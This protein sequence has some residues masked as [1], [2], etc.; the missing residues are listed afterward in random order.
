MSAGDIFSQTLVYIL[1]TVSCANTFF[2]KAIDD[3]PGADDELSAF[4]AFEAEVLPLIKA[5][6][7]SDVE[8]EC[9]LSRRVFPTTAPNRVFSLTGNGTVT[10]ESLPAN[11]AMN[12]RHFSGIGTKNQRGRWFFSG[13]NEARVVE[14]RMVGVHSIPMDALI[15]VVSNP[16]VTG[17]HEYR[18]QHFSKTVNDFFDIENGASN[19]IPTKMRN[20]TPGIC[21]IS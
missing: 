1:D 10:G 19:P 12:I 8:Y 15:T 6:Q 2:L 3:D 7:S 14:G 18:M 11:V 4:E 13:L 9:V 21:S 5:I 17:P 20:R 16:I